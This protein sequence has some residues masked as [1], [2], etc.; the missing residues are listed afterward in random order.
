MKIMWPASQSYFYLLF[1][2]IEMNFYL[3]SFLYDVC[4]KVHDYIQ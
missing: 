4:N 1:I 3:L 2:L